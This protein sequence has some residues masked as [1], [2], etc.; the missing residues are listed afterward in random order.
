MGA[1]S[2]KTCNSILQLRHLSYP[3]RFE[4]SFNN[5]T[6]NGFTPTSTPILLAESNKHGSFQSDPNAELYSNQ[7]LPEESVP[8]S[9]SACP[10]HPSIAHMIL[11]ANT[12]TTKDQQS[13]WKFDR[14]LS[15]V[16]L[17]GG[18]Y[19]QNYDGAGSTTTSINQGNG[20][21]TWCLLKRTS[22]ENYYFI[23]EICVTFSHNCRGACFSNGQP[24]YNRKTRTYT[25]V[26]SK[27]QQGL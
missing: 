5:T 12:I 27:L 24:E 13:V 20:N 1:C 11:A 19:K 8:W 9:P 2:T 7:Q 25:K 17:L 23:A 3:A 14:L 18:S 16:Q 26:Q 15:Q 4:K 22:P 21:G 6:L 10:H